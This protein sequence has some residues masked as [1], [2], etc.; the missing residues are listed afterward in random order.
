VGQGVV[1]YWGWQADMSQVYARC[2]IVTAPTMYGEGVPTVLLEAAACGRAI[3]ATDMP[4]CRDIV[5]DGQNGLI[6]PP[7]DA[8][9]LA[10]ALEKLVVDPGLRGRMG[11][12]GRQFVLQRF[13]TTQVNAAT[14]AVYRKVLGEI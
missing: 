12:A 7:G 4:G 5:L 6:I 11:N 8:S 2:H 1:E 13:T 3:V 14:L 9:A 10:A